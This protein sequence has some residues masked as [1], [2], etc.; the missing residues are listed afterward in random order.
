M[1]WISLGGFMILPA[2]LLSR[3]TAASSVDEFVQKLHLNVIGTLGIMLILIFVFI[4]QTK[5]S[6][7]GKSILTASKCSWEA[8][9]IILGPFGAFMITQCLFWSFFREPNIS[10]W[11]FIHI[12][13]AIICLSGFVAFVHFR[14]KKFMP[15]SL[16]IDENQLIYTGYRGKRKIPLQE[17]TKM[18]LSSGNAYLRIQAANISVN[19]SIPIYMH[20][21]EDIKTCVFELQR[22][23]QAEV[24]ER[25]ANRLQKQHC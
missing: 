11:Q 17:I 19:L 23:T 13:F 5:Q 20:E 6:T 8:A 25:L 15:A 2:W 10:Q 9:L 7:Q 21:W 16:M 12:L 24:Q 22:L 4:M 3:P 18:W 1:K 14:I